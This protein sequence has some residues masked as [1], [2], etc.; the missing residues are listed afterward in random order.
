MLWISIGLLIAAYVGVFAV[1][2]VRKY[3]MFVYDDWDLAY[4]NQLM[5]GLM[6][7]RPYISL[8]DVYFLGNHVELILALILP[9]YALFQSPATLLVIQTF[10][11]GLAAVPL[12]LIVRRQLNDRWGIIFVVIYLLYPAV[13]Y[14]NLNEFH[15]ESFIPFLQFFLLYYFLGSDFRRFALFM[16]L[17]LF[18]KENM[19]LIIMMLGFYA[20]L[21]RREKRWILLPVLSGII[22]F[23][24]YL[25]ILSPVLSNGNVNYYDFYAPLGSNFGELVVNILLHPV[26]VI[27]TILVP[28]KLKYLAELFGP[29]SFL[30]FLSPGMLSITLPNFLQHLLSSRYSETCLF[31]YY[32]SEIMAVIFVSAVLGLRLLL[33]FTRVQR[34]QAYCYV[35][36]PVVA[37]ASGLVLAAP[38]FSVH[39]ELGTTYGKS[40]VARVKNG[41]IRE[42]PEGAGVVATFQFLPKLSTMT[43]EL[44]SFHK[45]I[46]HAYHSRK[47]F[48][49]PQEVEFALIDF[50]DPQTFGTFFSFPAAGRNLSNFIENGHWGAIK[51]EN[52][53]VLF[54]RGHQGD[55]MVCATNAFVAS[56]DV[57]NITFDNKVRLAGY[58]VDRSELAGKKALSLSFFW[59]VQEKIEG[60]YWLFVVILDKN[61]R[62]A[63]Q[64]IHPLCYRIRPT[65]TWEKGE[66]LREDYRLSIPSSLDKGSYKLNIGLFNVATKQPC[67][68]IDNG[69]LPQDDR[70]AQLIDFEI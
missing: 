60:D 51:A 39:K 32:P 12:F 46:V 10:M 22:W 26:Q 8:C 57:V 33:Q 49:L 56:N 47:M 14:T 66:T 29:L 55:M 62:V 1:I 34:M 3:L 41:F 68:V 27:K 45:V 15:P 24:L 63:Y 9:I 6:H 40:E 35:I 38:Q 64:T 53:V 44:Y 43:D 42:I 18:A 59:N 65:S 17:C 61:G 25:K 19:A 31:Y 37:V 4:Y 20:L 67:R 30:S 5:R 21:M 70:L 13:G 36:V 28:E 48:E 54:K 52:N 16:F 50:G 11:L 23:L 7:G 69:K 58:L 2:C